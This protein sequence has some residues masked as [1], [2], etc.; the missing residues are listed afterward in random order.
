M[1]SDFIIWNDCNV[2]QWESVVVE[3]VCQFGSVKFIQLMSRV[4]IW[5]VFICIEQYWYYQ[6]QFFMF[7]FQ[8]VLY[9]GYCI[10]YEV[11][12]YM[13]VWC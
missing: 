10:V 8:V 7:C 11:E 6:W 3:F 5:V 4:W 13:F 12:S 9:G 1:V 2:Y